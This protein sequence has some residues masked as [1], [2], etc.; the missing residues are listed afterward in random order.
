MAS[1]HVPWF[2][3]HG[4]TNEYEFGN[5]DWKARSSNSNDKLPVP[6]AWERGEYTCMA[7]RANICC[8]LGMATGIQTGDQLLFIIIYLICVP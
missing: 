5:K 2:L 4:S 3:N 7:S 1:P 6:I 8:T